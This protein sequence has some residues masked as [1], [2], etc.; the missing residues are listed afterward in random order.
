ME[1]LDVL[2]MVPNKEEDKH[3]EETS[4]SQVSILKQPKIGKLNNYIY[5]DNRKNII[6]KI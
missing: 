4:T 3:D 6:T 2:K 5:H 1:P